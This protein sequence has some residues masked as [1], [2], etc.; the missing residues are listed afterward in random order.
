MS[1]VGVGVD[2]V[3]ISDL[4][5]RIRPTSQFCPTHGAEAPYR[6]PPWLQSA[7]HSAPLDHGMR[8]GHPFI[9]WQA[10]NLPVEEIPRAN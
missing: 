9:K 8:R 3:N 4:R 2:M 7:Q 1:I 10:R 6:K 5:E